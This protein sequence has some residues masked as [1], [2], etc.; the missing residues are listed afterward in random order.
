MGVTIE[1]GKSGK[2]PGRPIYIWKIY[3]RRGK[4]SHADSEIIQEM[5]KQIYFNE[6]PVYH[7][8]NNLRRDRKLLR[9]STISKQKMNSFFGYL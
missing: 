4:K 9:V 7:Q 6:D 8:N 2:Y 1:N 5:H 3:I